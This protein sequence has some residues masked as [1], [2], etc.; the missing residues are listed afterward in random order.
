MLFDLSSPR[1]KNVVRVVYGALAVLFAGGFILFGIGSESGAGGLF[2][3][4]FGDG[5]GSGSTAEQYEQQ[6]EDAESTLETDPQN[7]TAL[8]TLAQ[9]RYLSGAAQL[10][11]DEATLQPTLTEDARQ[12]L[13]AAVDA[14]NRYLDTDPKNP[15]VGTAGNMVQAFVLLG[16][17]EGAIEAQKILVE[18]NPSAGTYSR[19][20]SFYYADLNFKAGDEAAAKAVADAPKADRKQLEK[21]LDGAREFYVKQEKRLEKLPADSATGEQALDSPFGGLGGE[22]PGIPAPVAP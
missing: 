6:I 5:G 14:W 20:A 2:D 17:A 21:Q 22:Q 10:E 9:Y 1:R 8:T 19:L 13:E 4:L 15:N 16:D 11:Q 18:A 3:G 7:A 12:E